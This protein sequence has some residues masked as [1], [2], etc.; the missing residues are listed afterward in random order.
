MFNLS[1]PGAINQYTE[2]SNLHLDKLGE[3]PKKNISD[4][5]GW[6]NNL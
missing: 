2:Y 6:H 5:P 1:K 3:P 4:Q